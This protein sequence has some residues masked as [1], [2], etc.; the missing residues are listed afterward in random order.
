MTQSVIDSRVIADVVESACQAPSVHNSQPWRWLVSGGVGGD[1]EV[2]LFLDPQR[3]PRATDRTGRE[4]VI[5]CGAALDHLQVSSAAVGWHAD[6]SRF[7]NPN[8][9]DH[10]ATATLR[11]SGFVTEAA[12]GRAAAIRRRRTDRLPFAAPRAFAAFE[13]VLRSI[14]DNDKATLHVLPADARPQ[15]AQASRLTESLRRYDSSYQAELLWW[16]EVSE[17]PGGLPPNVLPSAAESDRV[18]IGRTFP[19]GE[20]PDRRPE[21]DRDHSVVVVLST[22]GDSR[23]D[24]LGCGEVLSE[25]LLEATLAGMATCTLS[26]MTEFEASREIIAALTGGS[27]NPQLLIRIG[28]VPASG[29]QPSAT[30]RRPMPEVLEVHG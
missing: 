27:G 11:G 17:V 24:A 14:V 6:I 29:P 28:E 5:S 30:P 20:H 4:A 26:H 25:V 19:A 15:L 2:R 7:P 22:R 1:S 21:V 9:L 18:D 16:T 23:R 3:V 10:L 8:D 13:A 12:R